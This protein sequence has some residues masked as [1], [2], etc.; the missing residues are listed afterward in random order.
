M[1][2]FISKRDQHYEILTHQGDRDETLRL[3]KKNLCNSSVAVFFP[4]LVMQ[5]Y[6]YKVFVKYQTKSNGL[7]TETITKYKN[8]FTCF[9]LSK[10]SLLKQNKIV[11]LDLR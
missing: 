6:S 9:M 8:L 2:H 1:F 10:I 5:A 3:H 4:V 7:V 11:Q